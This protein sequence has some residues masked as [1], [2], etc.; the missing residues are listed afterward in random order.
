MSPFAARCTLVGAAVLVLVAALVVPVA[1]SLRAVLFCAA[2][3]C[4]VLDVLVVRAGT[5]RLARGRH[6][7]VDEVVLAP[8]SAKLDLRAVDD[9]AGGVA[10]G[11]PVVL[12][13]TPD[14]RV[15]SVD[16]R[17]GPHVVVIGSG[18]LALAVFRAVAAQVRAAAGPNDD[19]RVAS[20]A[21]ARGLVGAGTDQ[22]PPMPSGTAAIVVGTPDRADGDGTSRA[23]VVLVPGLSVVPRLW[24][25]AVEVTRHGCTVRFPHDARGTDVVPALPRLGGPG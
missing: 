8:T 20:S 4:A 21:D 2:G 6:P 18:A 22:C 10:D 19:V 23:T 14:G 13:T 3:C 24:D 16:A 12:G 7:E 15:V 1:G 25:V 9:D 5:A 17:S 11:R